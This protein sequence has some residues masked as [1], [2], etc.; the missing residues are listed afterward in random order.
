[1]PYSR[2]TLS[3]ILS[4]VASD[5]QSQLKGSDPLLRFS[6]LNIVGTA[7][8]YLANGHYG[9]LDWIAM[10]SIP[11]T[12]IDE[13]I[14]A[15]GALKGVT[16][17]AATK[18]D[19]GQITFTGTNGTVINDQI[20]LVRGDGKTFTVQGSVTV[21][22]GVAVVNAIADNAGSAGNTS[23]GSVMTLGQSIAGIQS[24]GNV[25][26]EFTNGT[27][28]E[29]TPAYRTRMLQVYAQPPQGGAQSDYGEWA[30]EVAGVTRSWCNPNGAGP[31]TVVVYTMFDETESDHNGFPQGTDGVATYENRD[32]PATGDQLTVANYIYP[33]RPATAL[34]YSVSPLAQA[35]N[36]TISGIPSASRSQVTAEIAALFVR[37][38]TATGGKILINNIWSI[39]SAV[40]G[41]TDFIITSPTSDIVTPVGY[42]PVVGSVVYS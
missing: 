35:V 36:F 27:D 3:Q 4:Q 38:G 17:I 16:P 11:F 22:S 6:N 29:T 30:L 2:M 40:S 15:W 18:A 37:N 1:M 23:V 14:Y 8:G 24:S 7:L 20:S 5:I 19:N 10:Q 21:I 33:L 25:T 9:Y 32:T 13:Y 39:I 42:L 41:V 34:V 12:A 31:G 28:D 26:A